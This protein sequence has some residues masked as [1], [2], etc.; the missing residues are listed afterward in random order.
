M[1]EI[2]QFTVLAENIT[3]YVSQAEASANIDAPGADLAQKIE[4]L[5]QRVLMTYI[6]IAKGLP[7]PLTSKEAARLKTGVQNLT[8]A[9]Q[10]DMQQ[11]RKQHEYWNELAESALA[12]NR[13]FAH[14]VA[15]E[16]KEQSANIMKAIEQSLEVVTVAIAALV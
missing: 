5:Q 3:K 16:R 9:L 15:C 8:E 4:S 13:K 10:S 14:A 7:V 11:H 12:D 6:R 2:S 1:E